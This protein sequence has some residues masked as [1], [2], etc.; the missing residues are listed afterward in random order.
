MTRLPMGTLLSPKNS[1]PET[2]LTIRRNVEWVKQ[3]QVLEDA[4][5]LASSIPNVSSLKIA[6]EDFFGADLVTVSLV[7]M[8]FYNDRLMG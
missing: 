3:Q 2:A 5:S 1:L 8:A 6:F 7:E 4:I